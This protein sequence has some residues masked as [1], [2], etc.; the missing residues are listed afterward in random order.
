MQEVPKHFPQ[1]SFLRQRALCKAKNPR[2]RAE[3][4]T[5]SEIPWNSEGML[6]AQFLNVV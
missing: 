3:D 6:D 5:A 1:V 4:P 2:Q